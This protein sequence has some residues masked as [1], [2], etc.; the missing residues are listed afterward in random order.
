[1]NFTLIEK[2]LGTLLIL[3]IIM[4]IVI[5]FIPNFFLHLV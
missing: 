1:M 4:T 3:T 2:L 5:P